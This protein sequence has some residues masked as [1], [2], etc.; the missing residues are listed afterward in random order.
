MKCK[1]CA[2][3]MEKKLDLLPPKKGRGKILVRA[4]YS[5]GEKLPHGLARRVRGRDLRSYSPVKGDITRWG[6]HRRHCRYDTHS[7]WDGK[8]WICPNANIVSHVEREE[9]LKAR[10]EVSFFVARKKGLL[11][12]GS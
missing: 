1:I 11:K 9:M 10:Q 6:Y 2:A 4:Y 7:A 5:R 8:T 3:E 12:K